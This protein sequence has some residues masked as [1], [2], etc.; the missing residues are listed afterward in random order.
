MQIH[1]DTPENYITQLPA[2]RKEAINKLRSTILN[3]IPPGFQ[4]TIS[5]GMIGFAVP[6]TA[7]PNGYHAGKN[8]PLPFINIASQKNFV[9]LYHMGL[10]AD[11]NLLKWFKSEFPKCSKSRLDMGKSC[12]RFRNPDQIPYGLIG[13]LVKKISPDDWINLYEKQLN[14]DITKNS[15]GYGKR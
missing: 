2:D 13:E 4:E 7:Y 12:I 9:T 8:Q 11:E 1:A 6:L 14:K 5:Y 10:Y 3:N 15:R